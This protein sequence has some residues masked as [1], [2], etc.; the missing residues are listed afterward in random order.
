MPS[1]ILLLRAINVGARRIPMPALRELLTA[2]GLEDVRTYV[3][4]GNVVLSS[5]ASPDELA[6][7]CRELISSQFGFDVPVIVR[8][9]DELE[10]V[11][12]H[13]PF[14]DIATQ[15]KLLHVAFL[16]AEIEPPALER[17]AGLVQGEE[18]IHAHG[19]ELYA[20]LAHGSARSKLAVAMASPAQG[21][22]ATARNWT[23]VTTLLSMATEGG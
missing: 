9:R 15:P 4:S 20:W 14:A 22:T 12:E 6:T 10:A 7:S 18:R 13:D 17:L 2:A 8:T 11:V 23:T 1:R 3:Q 5:D 21:V 19:R 16:Q